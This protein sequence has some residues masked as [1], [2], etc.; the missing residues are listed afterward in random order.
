M[1]EARDVRLGDA[2]SEQ[3][4]KKL[5][6]QRLKPFHVYL[7]RSSRKSGCPKFCLL[8]CAGPCLA[9]FLSSNPNRNM[10]LNN[11]KRLRLQV[12]LSHE[13]NPFL[14]NRDGCYIDCSQIVDGTYDLSAVSDI[15]GGDAKCVGVIDA[16]S[17]KQVLQCV[18]TSRFLSD[19]LKANILSF[20]EG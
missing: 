7:A 11:E 6:F 3:D 17:R 12:F 2:L 4:K 5:L 15:M 8:V 13:N 10:I 1:A 14:P 19:I 18:R 9:F 20:L 16:E